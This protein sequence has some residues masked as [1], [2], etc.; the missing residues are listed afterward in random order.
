MH[1]SSAQREVCTKGG[2]CIAS[3]LKPQ[4]HAHSWDQAWHELHAHIASPGPAT[5]RC[6][7]AWRPWPRKRAHV[8]AQ[9]LLAAPPPAPPLQRALHRL[10]LGS[11]L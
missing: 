10:Q 4:D 9:P 5:D 2:T 3:V 8:V 7:A 1:V 6:P 11:V